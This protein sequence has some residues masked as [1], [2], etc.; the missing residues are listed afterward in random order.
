MQDTYVAWFEDLSRTDV[1]LV[2]GKNA[3]LGEM[4][5][6]LAQRGIRVPGGFATT[7]KAYRQYVAANDIEP[8]MRRWLDKLEAG[9]ASLQQAGEAIRHAFLEGVFPAEIE[10]MISEAYDDL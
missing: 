10:A 9:A 5:G 8:V 2:G 3:S 7:A 4:V 6:A 1:A